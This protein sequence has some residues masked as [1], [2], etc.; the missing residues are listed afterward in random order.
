MP[1]ANKERPEIS[2]DD[3]HDGWTFGRIRYH[4]KIYRYTIKNYIEPSKYGINRGCISKLHIS[5]GDNVLASYDR[6][7]L[8]KP[9]SDVAKTVYRAILR[10][11]NRGMP[12]KLKQIWLETY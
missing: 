5:N 9:Q 3:I 7:W 11:F 4:N 2:V 12:D 1:T 10:R 8:K 6:G